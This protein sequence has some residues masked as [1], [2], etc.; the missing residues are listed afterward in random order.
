MLLP[1]TACAAAPT[2]AQAIVQARVDA[3]RTTYKGMISDAY[4]AAMKVEESAAL[5]ERI[6]TA[7]ATK[8]SVYVAEDGGEVV[9][10]ASGLMLAE[11]KFGLDAELSPIYL[12]WNRQRTGTGRRLVA[13]VVDAQRAHGASGLLTWVIA[14]NKAARAFYETFGAEL[15]VEQPF[16]WT[17]WI[18]WKQATAGA[19]S[20][21]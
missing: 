1:S 13:A 6:L 21:R 19:I 20:M 2:D 17:A 7:G 15:L 18:W 12:R 4:L 5:W 14:E 10:F 11:P 9:A 8:T 3:W 16:Q